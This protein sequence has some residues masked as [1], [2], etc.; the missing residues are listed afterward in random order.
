MTKRFSF[1]TIAA[2]LLIASCKSNI[3]KSNPKADKNEIVTNVKSSIENLYFYEIDSFNTLNILNFELTK[4]NLKQEFEQAE[5]SFEPIIN[6]H[7]PSIIDTVINIREGNNV[8]NFYNLYDNRIHLLSFDLN[9]EKHKIFNCIE[10]GMK[11]KELKNIFI[12]IDTSYSKIQI[13]QIGP[14]TCILEFENGIITRITYDGY[15]D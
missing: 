15:V 2:L 6:T 14:N 11:K 1:L 5:W 10:I 3:Q 8:F 13:G 4:P 7:N 9:H 12:D